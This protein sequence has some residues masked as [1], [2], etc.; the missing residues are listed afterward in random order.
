MHTL[1]LTVDL[2]TRRVVEA[3]VVHVEAEDESGAFGIRPG[4][5]PFLTAL[6]VGLLHH[7]DEGG[8]EGWLAVDEGFLLTDGRSVEV[9][10]HD[11]H[12]ADSPEE[13]H[14]LL[15]GTFA[16]RHTEEKERRNA[17]WKM[18]LAAFKMLFGYE[19]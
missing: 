11:A 18:Q 10:T 12:L 17:L 16:Q 3:D 4:H 8:R 5:E 6:T 9:Y 2:P 1:R 19:R 13:I 15:E 7:R 14:R